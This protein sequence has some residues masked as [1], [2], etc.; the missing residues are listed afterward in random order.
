MMIAN[1]DSLFCK[2]FFS[3]TS[4][5]SK[6]CNKHQGHFKQYDRISTEPENNLFIFHGIVRNM[7]LEDEERVNDKKWNEFGVLGDVLRELQREEM[8]ETETDP[9][10]TPE[11]GITQNTIEILTEINATLK[12]MAETQKRIL[13]EI[14]KNSAE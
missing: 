5:I 7:Y 6:L 12:E 9:K 14:K 11:A 10:E 1:K 2:N 3:E 8:E 13:E 4:G